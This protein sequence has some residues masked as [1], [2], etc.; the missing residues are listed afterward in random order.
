MNR[1][2]PERLDVARPV[3]ITGA[4]GFVGRRTVGTFLAL[5]TRVRAIC[6]TEAGVDMVPSGADSRVVGDIDTHTDW[7][8]VLENVNTVVHLAARVHVMNDHASDPLALYREVN[9]NGTVQL[10]RAAAE[11]G[12]RRF[13]FVS[14]IKANGEATAETPFSESSV[15]APVDPYGISKLEAEQA[16]HAIAAETGLE[17]VVLRPPLIYGPGVGANFRR[18]LNAVSR[19]VPLP[20]GAIENRRSLLFVGNMVNALV[21]CVE[22]PSAAGETFLVSDGPSVSSAELVTEISYA[23]GRR[24]RLLRISPALL[25]AVGRVTG[26][27]AAVQRLVGSL[28][29]DSSRIRKVLDWTPPYSMREGLLETADWWR[30]VERS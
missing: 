3:A 13:V 27:R 18:L 1:S 14:S 28:E 24:P 25:D 6:R 22:H 11:V 10:A 17:V 12:V 2:L 9:V 29:V 21:Q 23:L 5:G 8:G 30:T 20:F 19:G 15:P 4:N 16:L 7:S 26:R